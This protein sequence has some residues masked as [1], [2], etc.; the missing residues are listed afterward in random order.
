MTIPNFTKPLL[1]LD[2][3]GPLNP[4][5]LLDKSG[6]PSARTPS[7]YRVHSMRPT[8]WDV[9]HMP[10]LRVLLNSWHGEQLR[11]LADDHFTLVWA[12]TWEHDANTWI[13]PVL[14]LPDLPVIEF[15]EQRW[16]QTRIAGN[17]SF[18]TPTIAAWTRRFAPGIPWAWVDDQVSGR[19]DRQWLRRELGPTAPPFLTMRINPGEGLVAEHFDRLRAFARDAAR[20]D[21]DQVDGD[22]SD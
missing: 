7:H 17:D 10:P 2:V 11:S 1:L 12:T 5:A 14:G 9:K 18:K 6:R 19:R 3:D 13:A 8:G 21:D 20:Q 22:P 15:G 16:T 4:F